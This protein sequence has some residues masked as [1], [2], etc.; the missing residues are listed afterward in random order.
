MSALPQIDLVTNG[1]NRSQTVGAARTLLRR[2]LPANERDDRF[3]LAWELDMLAPA[4]PVWSS[5]GF[6][7]DTPVALLVGVVSDSI[8]R[9]EAL[10][11]PQLADPVGVLWAQLAA[12][13]PQSGTINLAQRRRSRFGLVPLLVVWR[14]NRARRL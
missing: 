8:L 13:T 4:T 12:S 6:Q 11:D 3:D 5:I 7:G 9:L 14:R 2:A 1:S 10:H